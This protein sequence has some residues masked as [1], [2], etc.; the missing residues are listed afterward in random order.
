MAGRAETRSTSTRLDQT[1]RG[2]ERWRATRRH[3][4]AAMPGPLWDA[5]VAAARQHGLY[6]TARTL[7]VDYGA[8]K[9]HLEARAGEA[10]ALAAPRFVELVPSDLARAPACVI[11][12]DGPRGMLRIRL[13]GLAL[14]DL[15]AVA[16]RWGEAS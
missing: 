8:L 1:R 2:I 14:R 6:R 4:Q 11:E 16:Q 5:A 13:E 12:I 3:R 9:K 10:A 7:C 15:V